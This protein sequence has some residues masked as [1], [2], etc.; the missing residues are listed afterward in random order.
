MDSQ[1]FPPPQGSPSSSPPV[2]PGPGSV[3]PAG[4]SRL[5][6]LF[7]VL[8][9][10]L[11]IWYTP[12]LAERIKFSQTRGEVEAIRAGLPEL[13]LGA[14]GRA[15]GLVA[16]AA[17][18]S[19]V[20]IHTQGQT[21]AGQRVG[22]FIQPR[23]L[24]TSGQASGVIVDPEGYIVTNRHVIEGA[25]RITVQLS[26]GRQR[27]AQ[28]IGADEGTDLAV[29]KINADGLVAARWG[30]SDRLEV[31]ELVW[32]VGNP[33]G[34]DRSVTFGIVSAKGRRGIDPS[35]RESPFQEFLQTDAAVNPGNSG[36]PL[37]NID[38]EVVGIN[39]AIVGRAYQGISFAIPSNMAKDVYER[40]RAQGRVIR[41]YLGVSLAEVSAQLAEELGIEP[42]QGAIV[43]R[44]APNSPAAAADIR[45]GDVIV[46]WNGHPVENPSALTLLVARTEI[47]SR[48]QVELIR[49]G[50]PLTVEV[51]VGERPDGI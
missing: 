48:A 14:L 7:L 3:Q 8:L 17:G 10:L 44:V 22:P 35:G 25:D 41:G 4:R 39:T 11:A 18:P 34:L 12:R 47:G 9:G 50:E 29:L 51:R 37:V 33:F 31:G 15:F 20:H 38:A 30:D 42:R 13:K 45:P 1:F 19:V 6:V 5:P 2:P 24:Q 16:R 27:P 36:G 49:D 23:I 40:I 21:L 26:D 43:V 32:A 46:S 28:L